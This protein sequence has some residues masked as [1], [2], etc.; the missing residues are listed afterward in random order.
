MERIV[1]VK[2]SSSSDIYQVTLKNENGLVSLN[3]TC[4][5]G[6]YRMI[7]KHRTSL[8]EG[9]VSNLVLESDVPVVLEFIE[10]VGEEKIENLFSGLF[11]IE[12]E[13]K[14]LNS[15]KKKIRKDIGFKFSDGF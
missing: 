10:S 7:C 4:Q 15:I 1:K 8:L 13:I 3:C 9:D 2:S 6:I 14:R 11:E 5:A 12:E